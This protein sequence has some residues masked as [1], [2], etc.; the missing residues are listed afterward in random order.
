MNKQSDFIPIFPEHNPLK[1]QYYSEVKN[2]FYLQNP[3]EIYILDKAEGWADFN[4]CYYQRDGHPAGWVFVNQGEYTRYGMNK[5][6]METGRNIYY[7]ETIPQQ[8][9]QSERIKQPK[10]QKSYQKSSQQDLKNPQTYQKQDDYYQTNKFNQPSAT[11]K[12]HQQVF[13]RFVQENNMQLHQIY[14]KKR[15]YQTGNQEEQYTSRQ[16]VQSENFRRSNYQ[17]NK[18]EGKFYNKKPK[19]NHGYNENYLN[20]GSN[21]RQNYHQHYSNG[22]FNNSD[23]RIRLNQST[24]SNYNRYQE[25]NLNNFNNNDHNTKRML[26]RS[27]EDNQRRVQQ[28]QNQ[29]YHNL[30]KNPFIEQSFQQQNYQNQKTNYYDKRNERNQIDYYTES[31]KFKR[32]QSAHDQKNKNYNGNSNHSNYQNKNYNINKDYYNYRQDNKGFQNETARTINQRNLQKR[33]FQHKKQ[34]SQQLLHHSNSYF[35]Q[36]QNQ[37][38]EE[39]IYYFGQKDDEIPRKNGIPERRERK[40]R[41]NQP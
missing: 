3:N 19:D 20:V 35:Q 26:N 17:E 7:P 11:L 5:R 6:I 1:F 14:I 39:K 9:M 16:R 41:L 2:G 13:Q 32:Q 8:G 27:N 4:G 28:F 33:D 12:E 21:G 10:D 23:P 18:N 36:E 34:Q 22:N 15:N 25:T 40:S 24:K 37:Q 38:D 31:D 29:K 30:I